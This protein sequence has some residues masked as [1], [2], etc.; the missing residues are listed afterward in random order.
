MMELARYD[1]ARKALE[2]AHAVDEVKDILDK[3]LAIQAYAR[4]AKDSGLIDRATEIRLRAERRLG[5]LLAEQ[6][7]TVGM[8]RGLA[9]TR[10]SGSG[11]EPVKDDRPTLA[12]VGIDKKLSARAQKLAALD[13]TAFEQRVET[14][15]KQAVAS[16]DSTSAERAA[17]KKDRRAEREAELA[18]KQLALP[19]KKYGV[20]LADPAWSFEPYSRETGM[21]RAADNHYA[22]SSLDT[23]KACGVPS[24]A[25]D[26]CVLF[27][28]ATAP[29]LPQALEV[30]AAWGFAY[31]S[32][33]VWTKEKDGTGYWNRSRHEHLL[34]GTKGDIPAPAMGTQWSS[35]IDAPAREHSV[36]PDEAM[37]MIEAYFPT[38]PRIELNARRPRPGW[39]SW[40]SDFV[41][42][43]CA[44]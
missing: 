42:F 14:A 20:V 30:M 11:K 18:A 32:N 23:I 36:K 16:V 38:L 15:K 12:D 44:A 8:N 6:K 10:V 1:A 27:L 2:E 31:K 28:W 29:M 25:A 9:G 34:I 21:D 17:E 41:S 39:D 4:Q 26:D 5:Y 43:E 24:I 13:E 19:K 22:T 3:A 7:A 37:Q 35:V 40:G 33:Y